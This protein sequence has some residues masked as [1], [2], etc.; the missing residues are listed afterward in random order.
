MKQPL[1]SQH[2]FRPHGVLAPRIRATDKSNR[3]ATVSRPSPEQ[4]RARAGRRGRFAGRQHGPLP[5]PPR[6][7]RWPP[8][9]AGGPD[10]VYQ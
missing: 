8:A 5:A 7:G 10:G 1:T 4:A 2:D 9:Q 3:A 6:L